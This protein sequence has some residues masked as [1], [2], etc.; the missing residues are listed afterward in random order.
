MVWEKIS[1][2]KLSVD[3]GKLFDKSEESILH[4]VWRQNGTGW[5]AIY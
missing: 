1:L 4:E 5:Y 2:S 3:G